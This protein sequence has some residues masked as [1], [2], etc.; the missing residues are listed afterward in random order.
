[1]VQEVLTAVARAAGAS[2]RR[3]W[4]APSAAGYGGPLVN[5]LRVLPLP[6]GR[7]QGSGDSD[8]QQMLDQLEDPDSPLSRRWDQEHDQYLAGRLLQVVERDFE[9]PT[10]LAFRRL[11]AGGCPPG[12]RGR[13]RP[14]D[15]GQRR[16]TSPS[17][18][19]CDGCVRRSRG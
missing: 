4:P 11:D 19:C 1:M 18:A 5:R 15:V 2:P 14:G 17:R 10:W 6:A 3:A 12:G 9:L 13:P 7:A 16:A 8:V